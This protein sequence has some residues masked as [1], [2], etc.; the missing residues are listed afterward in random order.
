M[1]DRTIRDDL[2]AGYVEC[3]ECGYPIERHDLSGYRVDDGVQC[4][5]AWTKEEIRRVRKENGLPAS[6]NPL[7]L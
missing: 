4:H 2:A 6:F 5:V 7:T 1:S 3:S